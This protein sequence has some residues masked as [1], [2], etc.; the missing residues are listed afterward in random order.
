MKHAAMDLEYPESVTAAA[1]MDLGANIQ[2]G[3]TE[4]RHPRRRAIVGLV[5]DDTA[6]R[7]MISFAASWEGCLTVSLRWMRNNA[8]RRSKEGGS[9]SMRWRTLRDLR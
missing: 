2:T 9:R 8:G 3:K 5:V 6:N 4:V 7:A 1:E